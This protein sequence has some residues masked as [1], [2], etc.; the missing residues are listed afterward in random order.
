MKRISTIVFLLILTCSVCAQT[1]VHKP[2]TILKVSGGVRPIQ[3]DRL[4]IEGDTTYR[5]VFQNWQYQQLTDVKT[6]SLA[7]KELPAF[8]KA[9]ATAQAAAMD[10]NVLMDAYSIRKIRTGL[11]GATHYWLY[12]DGGYCQLSEKD[13]RNLIEAVGKE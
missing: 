10:D 11:T 1:I 13:V 9:L 7:K 6:L 12:H 2:V 5:I 3:F 8:S 4:V